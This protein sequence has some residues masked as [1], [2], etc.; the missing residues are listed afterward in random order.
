M[1]DYVKRILIVIIMGLCVS[2]LFLAGK[3][4]ERDVSNSK[5]NHSIHISWMKE[6]HFTSQG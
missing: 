1:L 4:T 3:H 6:L 5:V 2:L